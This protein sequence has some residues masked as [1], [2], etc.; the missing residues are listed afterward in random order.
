MPHKSRLIDRLV[1]ATYRSGERRI[2]ADPRLTAIHARIEQRPEPKRK[3]KLDR[4]GRRHPALGGAFM[5]A[6]VVVC[7]LPLISIPFVVLAAVGM[8]KATGFVFLEGFMALVCVVAGVWMAI[9]AGRV[10]YQGETP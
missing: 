1:D 9:V 5:G 8:L 7:F 2:A 10:W 6:L 3:A 4:F